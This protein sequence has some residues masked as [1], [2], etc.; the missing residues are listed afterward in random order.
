LLRKIVERE[1]R[2]LRR[3]VAAE[4]NEAVQERSA[5]RITNITTTAASRK[6]VNRFIT[7][8]FLLDF[9]THVFAVRDQRLEPLE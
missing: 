4:D 7:T 1:M 2:F 8:G 5:L 3:S 6:R 9:E